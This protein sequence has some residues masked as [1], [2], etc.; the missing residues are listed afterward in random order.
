MFCR[1][2]VREDADEIKPQEMDKQG[3]GRIVLTGIALIGRGVEKLEKKKGKARSVKFDVVALK[4][5][6][7]KSH[8]REVGESRLTEWGLLRAR[9]FK[10]QYQQGLT[11]A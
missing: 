10:I 7:I 11:F 8:G 6:L 4:G 9:E 3:H 5:T 1:G 2:S